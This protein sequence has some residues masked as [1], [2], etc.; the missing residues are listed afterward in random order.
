MES[1]RRTEDE[2]ENGSKERIYMCVCVCVQN[3][4]CVLKWMRAVWLRQRTKATATAKTKPI[5]AVVKT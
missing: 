3:V 5:I 1:E 2:N 4:D